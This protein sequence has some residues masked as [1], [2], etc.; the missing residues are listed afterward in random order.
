LR[1]RS[2][3]LSQPITLMSGS[4]GNLR[5]P[6][7]D[8]SATAY[9]FGGDDADTITESTPTLTEVAMAPHPLGGL[10]TYSHLMLKQGTPG[11][12]SIIRQDLARVLATEIDR[13]AFNGS[14]VGTE[15]LG[16]LGTGGIT[17]VVDAA[18]DWA[19]IVQMESDLVAANADLPSMGYVASANM[20]PVLKTSAK[21]TGSGMFLWES[22]S[23][24]EGR[25][26][27]YPAM[28]SNQLPQGHILFA[29]WASFLFAEWG[30]LEITANPYTRFAQGSVQIRAIMDVDFG[31]RHAE[32]FSVI[33]PV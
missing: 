27:G 9:W 16:I 29:S 30:A 19:A 10:V 22:S 31:V 28:A 15:P 20:L 18:P 1:A 13:A 11:T 8:G 14:G 4:V 7:L 33:T 5:V 24:Y 26:N 3:I 32:S 25:M 6:K 2:A 17:S 23:S 12:E 21:D